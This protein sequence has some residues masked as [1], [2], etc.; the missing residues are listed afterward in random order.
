MQVRVIDKPHYKVYVHKSGENRTVPHRL[1]LLVC[2][3]YM[4]MV[5]ASDVMLYL[6]KDDI[7]VQVEIGNYDSFYEIYM[8][9]FFSS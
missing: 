3:T 8:L 7:Y 2:Y 6:Y 4:L 5:Y 1:H 9:S